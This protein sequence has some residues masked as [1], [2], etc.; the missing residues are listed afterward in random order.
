MESSENLNLLTLLVEPHPEDDQHS[1]D[2]DRT[3]DFSFLTVSNTQDLIQF[4]RLHKGNQGSASEQTHRCNVCE[5]CVKPNCV[6]NMIG[7]DICVSCVMGDECLVKEACVQ[8][9]RS[10]SNGYK[11]GLVSNMSEHTSVLK[12]LGCD[13][14][15]KEGINVTFRRDLGLMV[16]ESG[17]L[18]SEQLLAMKAIVTLFPTAQLIK[19]TA[20]KVGVDSVPE[21]TTTVAGSTLYTAA[22]VGGADSTLLGV[23]STNTILQP[24]RTN[25]GTKSKNT[26]ITSAGATSR[27]AGATS[28]SAGAT[29]ISANTSTGGSNGADMAQLMGVLQTLQKDLHDQQHHTKKIQDDM[30]SKIMS[31]TN[32]NV[33]LQQ[34]LLD[35]SVKHTQT[36][37]NTGSLFGSNSSHPRSNTTTGV[38]TGTSISSNG[39][40]NVGSVGSGQLNS[41]VTGLSTSTNKPF[42]FGDFGSNTKVDREPS[43]DPITRL[44]EVLEKT[45]VGKDDKK[46]LSAIQ[47]KSLPR[48]LNCENEISV[49]DFEI[50]K[51]SIKKVFDY[52][53]VDECLAI[54]LIRTECGLP[55]RLR[56][57]IQQCASV[58]ECFETFSRMMV[59]LSCLRPQLVRMLTNHPR[60]GDDEEEQLACLDDMLKKIMNF[61]AFFADD[62]I[63]EYETVAALAC[64]Q[65]VNHVSR[66]PQLTFD[67][68][69]QHSQGRKYIDILQ[70]HLDNERCNLYLVTTARSLYQSETFNDPS[71]MNVVTDSPERPK[72]KPHHY[73]GGNSKREGFCGVCRTTG[74]HPYWQCPF[75]NEVKDAKRHIKT[76]KHICIKCLRPPQACLA[77]TENKDCSQVFSK[78][79][80]S[81]YSLLC[82]EH[83]INKKV[84]SCPR[85]V[86]SGSSVGLNFISLQKESSLLSEDSQTERGK[87]T[88]STQ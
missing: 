32:Q 45:L 65:S 41:G 5:Q 46:A 31:L 20:N 73:S 82:D 38:C 35:Q 23:T 22:A 61:K 56:E 84:C 79:K 69:R 43:S 85:K 11:A 80:Q 4:E 67:F 1:D 36:M 64:F 70:A 75:L 74:S 62:D 83:K 6:E 53:K 18:N 76:L 30:H 16:K 14:K 33:A 57:A 29:S 59:P 7:E 71:L 42:S 15:T 8:W 86:Q 58:K 3:D 25:T 49:A 77:K 26:I 50:W 72:Q 10:Q 47:I 81:T 39:R 12:S 60:V 27:S 24:N 44:S 54:Q 66:L 68:K 88:Q 13:V 28:T 17:I 34:Q 40:T 55:H 78:A 51:R 19:D 9:S 63:N 48:L 87:V 21:T 52:Y 2:M 37:N